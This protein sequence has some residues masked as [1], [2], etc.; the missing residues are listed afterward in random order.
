MV[1][2]FDEIT[3]RRNTASLKW[4]TVE[5][6]SVIPLWVADMDF[7]T[8][9]A[10]TEAVRARVDTGIYG[11]VS[12]PESYFNSIISWFKRRHDWTIARESILTTI[13]VVPAVS[14][15]VK[16]LTH[17]GDG[18]ILQTPAYNCFFGAIKNTG[19]QVIPNPLVRVGITDR[20]FSYEIDFENLEALASDVRNKVLLLC[21]PHNPTGRIWTENE[22]ETVREICS[23]HGV[24]VISDEIHCELTRNSAEYVPYATID[25]NAIICCSPSKA[26][27]IAG[28][29]NANI[30]CPD[31]RLRTDISFA[32]KSNEV[33]DLNPLGVS[34]VTAAYDKGEDWL[35][36]L[37]DYLDD[38][39]DVLTDFIMKNLPA[40]K[41][42][43]SEATYLAWIDVSGSGMDGDTLARYMLDECKVRVSPGGIY[44][45]SNYIRINYACPRARLLEALGRIR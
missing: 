25:P 9:P 21:N 30:I 33:L 7:R 17:P 37:N 6:E 32:L 4:D 42:C 8:A 5:D 15:I 24:I 45:D 43:D 39:Y 14:A 2:N 35:D 19:C 1:Y 27:N 20:T 22:L 34:G 28:L 11:Y 13:G 23:R 10:V 16:A 18:V 38:N 29:Q 3:N 40:W 36:A 31:D 44:G 12:L 41:I 26:F